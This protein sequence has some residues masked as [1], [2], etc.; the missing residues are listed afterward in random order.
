MVILEGVIFWQTDFEHLFQRVSSHPAPE[1]AN[2]SLTS[3]FTITHLLGSF[4]Q[5]SLSPSE[6]Q[7]LLIIYAKVVGYVNTEG[8]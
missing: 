7:L 5:I 3:R 8:G 1:L 4:R 2:L 6:H